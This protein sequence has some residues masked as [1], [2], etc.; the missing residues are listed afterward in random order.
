M[1]PTP[2]SS[3]TNSRTLGLSAVA[4]KWR[5]DAELVWPGSVP[6]LSGDALVIATYAK[7]RAARLP[8]REEGQTSQTEYITRGRAGPPGAWKARAAR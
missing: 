1:S 2:R 6:P 4:C 5:L 3:A 7:S 8:K